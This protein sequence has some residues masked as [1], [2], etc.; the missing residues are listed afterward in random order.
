MTVDEQSSNAQTWESRYIEGYG[1][2]TSAMF[3]AIAQLK[4]A[5]D[6]GTPFLAL[7]DVH[8]NTLRALARRDWI[9][10]SAS[11]VDGTK[12]KLT[13][14]GAKALRVFSIPT[15]SRRRDGMCPACE[16]RPKAFTPNGKPYGYCYECYRQKRNRH[17]RL[18]GKR[19]KPGHVCP[20]CNLREVYKSGSGRSNTYCRECKNELHR[21]YNARKRQDIVARILAGEFIPCRKCGERPIYLTGNTPQDMCFECYTEY[22]HEWRARKK[23]S[24]VTN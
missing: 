19:S 18:F 13:G 23:K 9:I 7:D 4:A 17:F 3:E 2:C 12:Y 6:A 15:E 24:D 21:E 8:K 20:R 16:K 5:Q 1:R 11:T 10:A 14:R 22:R